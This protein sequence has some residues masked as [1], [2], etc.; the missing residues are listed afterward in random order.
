MDRKFTIVLNGTVSSRLHSSRPSRKNAQGK[1]G[2]VTTLPVEQSR[3]SKRQILLLGGAFLTWGALNS[4]NVCLADDN[5]A[6]VD[7]LS[8]LERVARLAYAD[9]RFDEAV[10]AINDMIA[11]DPRNPSLYE[12]RATTLVDGKN[13]GDAVRDFDNCLSFLGN[14]DSLEKARLLSGKALALEGLDDFSGAADLYQQ[15]VDMA[16]RSGGSPDPYIVNS[17]GNCQ[18]SMG[19][20]AKARK[21]YLESAASFQNS[22]FEDGVPGRM[23]RRL[24]GS[25]FAFSNAALML[26]QMGDDARAIKEM[27]NIARRAPGSADMRAAL[28]AMYWNLGEEEAAESEW[29]FACTNIAVGCAKYQD[30]DWL[31]RVR[32]WPPVMTE[33]LEAFLKLRSS[34]RFKDKMSR[35]EKKSAFKE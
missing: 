12:M 16:V 32:R 33:R 25:I 22:R 5:A 31:R 11:L 20:W 4:R 29:G 27:Q 7:R 14:G 9:R 30:Q 28:A 18:A 17:L 1:R 6:V 10:R 8:E 24:D 15:S 3:T 21:S 19:E 35:S 34:K 23:Q 26:V 2:G 13:F